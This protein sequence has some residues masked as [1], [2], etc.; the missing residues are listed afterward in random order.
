MHSCVPV[1]SQALGHLSLPLDCNLSSHPLSPWKT[2]K[3][4]ILLCISR[5]HTHS[6]RAHILYVYI[7]RVLRCIRPHTNTPQS[8]SLC[9]LPQPNCAEDT[10]YLTTLPSPDT[11][12]HNCVRVAAH[13][14]EHTSSFS[15]SSTVAL[16]GHIQSSVSVERAVP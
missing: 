7:R 2:G 4:K 5:R 6:A 12:P 13:T 11:S 15:A 3:P 9:S 10:L 8:V 1:C 16:S 14:Q